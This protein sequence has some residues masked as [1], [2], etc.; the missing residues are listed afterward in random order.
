MSPEQL[1][2]T[3]GY[4][5]VAAGAFAEGETFLILGGFAAHNGY[6][7]LPWVIFAAFAGA[8]AGDQL[9]FHVGRIKGAGLLARYPRWQA[10]S[11]RVYRLLHAHQVLLI[12]GFRVL[13]GLR[14][15][16][17]FIIGAGGIPPL[18]FLLLDIVG[19]T[20]WASAVGTLGYLF[21]YTLE[22]LLGDIRHYEMWVFAAL[23]V[24]GSAVWL[25]LIRKR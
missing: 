11:E 3:Y 4:A 19:A 7:E 8:L 10:R 21:G 22:I 14:V 17:P 1:I 25:M 12:L 23:A 6:L 16:T 18:R 5:A 13:Y 9:S 24:A 2:S 20:V 15:L